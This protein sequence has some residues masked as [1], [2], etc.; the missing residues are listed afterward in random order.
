MKYIT[1]EDAAGI[2]VENS[3]FDCRT[4]YDLP[5]EVSLELSWYGEVGEMN[6]HTLYINYDKTLQG[7][8]NALINANETY[9]AQGDYEAVELIRDPARYRPQSLINLGKE[10]EDNIQKVNSWTNDIVEAINYI[11]WGEAGGGRIARMYVPHFYS[12]INQDK[13]N[14]DPQFSKPAA[15]TKKTHPRSFQEAMKD[16]AKAA[17]KVNWKKP[18]HKK[19]G[20]VR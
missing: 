6:R 8:K 14:Q 18:S 9:E 11:E 1:A 12:E 17:K 16:A 15:P 19:D 7:L 10:L 20:P 3:G 13:Q 2:I 4:N 5:M